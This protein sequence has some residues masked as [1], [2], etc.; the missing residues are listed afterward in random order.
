MPARELL[1][2]M[3]FE[4]REPAQALTAFELS[5]Q[6][7]PNRYHGLYGAARAAQLSGDTAKAKLYYERFLALAAKADSTRPEIGQ[8][9]A[10][11]AQR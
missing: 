10:Y 11:V 9:K 1:G 3:L 5:A 8:A 2:E 7:E 6:R 4:L